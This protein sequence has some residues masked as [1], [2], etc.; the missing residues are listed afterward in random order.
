MNTTLPS[1]LSILITTANGELSSTL[2]AMLRRLGLTNTR[3]ARDSAE[4]FRFFSQSPYDAM[5][6]DNAIGPE[7]GIAVTRRV[8][9]NAAAPNRAMAIV[10]VSGDMPPEQVQEARDAGIDEFVHLPVTAQILAARLESAI[11]APRPFVVA[12]DYAGPDRRRQEEP[13]DGED[14]RAPINRTPKTP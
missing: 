14:R 2:A 4:A 8:R 5:I 9:L 11:A 7:D 13:I 10:M 3:I 6:I 1:R 12:P